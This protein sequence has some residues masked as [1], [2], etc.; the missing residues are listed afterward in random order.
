MGLNLAVIA[1]F[2]VK[3]G[4]ASY[5]RDLYDALVKLDVNVYIIKLPR[6][7]IKTQE[8]IRNVA[9]SIPIKEIDIIHIQHEYGL[10]QDKEAD[11]YGILKRLGKPNITTMHAIGNYKID[12]VV[13]DYSDVVIVHNEFCKRLFAFPSVIIPHGC[14][15]NETMPI[16][17][18]KKVFG[19]D[20]RIPVVGY[21]GFISE[22]KG[23]DT[24]IDAMV[25][26]KNAGLLIGGGWHVGIDTNYIIRLKQKSFEVLQ[27]RCQWLGY[28]PDERLKTV[29]SAMDFVCYPSRWATESGALL[30]ALGYG[31]AVV[32]NRL[33]PFVEKEKKGAL[34]TFKGV[35]NLK[36]K[37]KRLLK[38]KDYRA[39]LEEGARNYCM[40]NSWENVAKKHLDVYNHV[41][42]KSK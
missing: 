42:E 24:L 17:E 29:Y 31:K 2:N 34:V 3:C 40:E 8:I 35:K 30:M 10:Y 21:C 7:G 6:F 13:A 26:V 28:V 14:K 22:A 32:A 25:D 9:E 20:S 39:K 27:G 15:L 38:D 1:P 36:R 18:A 5:S 4:V 16:D 19:V 12:S 23:L 33:F 37:I 41:L 11:L